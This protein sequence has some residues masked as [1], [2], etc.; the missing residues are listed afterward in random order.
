M[1]NGSST[2]WTASRRL[3]TAIVLL[4]LLLLGQSGCLWSLWSR[5]RASEASARAADVARAE[6]DALIVNRLEAIYAVVA[7]R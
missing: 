1:R 2:S 7:G 3:W 6:R 4:C 5:L